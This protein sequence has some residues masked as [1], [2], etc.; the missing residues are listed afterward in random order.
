MYEIELGLMDHRPMTYILFKYKIYF[1]LLLSAGNL[2]F[3][4]KKGRMY[5]TII[6][7]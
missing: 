1:R 7:M 4:Y 5:G 6:N 2:R 3:Q